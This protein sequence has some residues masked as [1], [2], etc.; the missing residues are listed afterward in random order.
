M[1]GFYFHSTK[2][3]SHFVLAELFLSFLVKREKIVKNPTK[4]TYLLRLLI[5]L[6]LNQI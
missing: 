2:T 4:I 5:E 3:A 6:L 1:I